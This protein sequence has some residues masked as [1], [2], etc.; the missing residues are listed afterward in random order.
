NHF[1]AAS[2]YQ[3]EHRDG[4]GKKDRRSDAFWV[5]LLE[6]DGGRSLYAG[7]T[8]NLMRRMQEHGQGTTKTTA[9]RRP[10]LAWFEQVPTR[11]AAVER[12]ADLK[13]R[14]DTQPDEVRQ[15]ARAFQSR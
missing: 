13:H 11:Q 9:G 7:Q 8:R 12:E 3:W 2:R 14:I 5:Y 1:L 6:L 10:Q 15:M 4:W